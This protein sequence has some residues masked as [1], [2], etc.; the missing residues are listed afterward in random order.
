MQL[1]IKHCNP[2]RQTGYIMIL[3]SDFLAGKLLPCMKYSILQ[4]IFI[5]A[6]YKTAQQQLILYHLFLLLEI[7]PI[8][9][10]ST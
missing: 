2:T 9:A 8:P 10:A 7:Q 3:L 6:E 1:Y 4:K 5:V